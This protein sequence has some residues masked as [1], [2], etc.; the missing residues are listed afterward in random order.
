MCSKW[1][2]TLSELIQRVLCTVEMWCDKLNLSVNPDKTGLVEFTRRRNLPGFFE[3][4]LFGTTLHC[5]MS[6]QYLGV[7]VDLRLV[8]RAHMD[9]KVR[10]AHN[11]LWAC[12]RAYAVMWGLRPRVVSCMYVSIIRLSV[13]FAFLLWWPGCQTTSAKKNLSRFQRACLGIT[14]AMC[15]IPTNAVE[16]LICL[17]HWS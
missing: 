2:T 17:P 4:H 7:I 3:P 16:V 13:T 5:S 8:W 10:K 15:T 14:E 11:L 6:V 12:R 9:V 1:H